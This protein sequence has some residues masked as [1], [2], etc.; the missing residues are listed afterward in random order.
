MG[1]WECYEIL[2]LHGCSAARVA[3]SYTALPEA[4][5]FLDS[6]MWIR[7][8]TCDVAGAALYTVA[9][10]IEVWRGS[11][12]ADIPLVVGPVGILPLEDTNYFVLRMCLRL[13]TDICGV[14]S[15]SLSRY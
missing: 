11:S 5:G 14:D 13:T 4:A 10:S 8:I 12:G 1:A 3:P 2:E 9:C 15:A 6:D 7:R